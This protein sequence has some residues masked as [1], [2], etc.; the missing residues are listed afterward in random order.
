[1][2]NDVLGMRRI[3]ARLV[4]RM[5]NLFQKEHRIAVAK[6]MLSLGQNVIEGIIIGDETWVYEYDI[7]TN[8]QSLYDFVLM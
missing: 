6:E 7:E 5:L 4:P 3:E 1:V 8:Q 2:M